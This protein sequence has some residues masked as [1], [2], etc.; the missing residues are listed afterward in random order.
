MRASSFM[1]LQMHYDSTAQDEVVK[2]TSGFRLKFSSPRKEELWMLRA[3]GGVRLFKPDGVMPP[4]RPAFFDTHACFM[5]SDRPMRVIL[6][7]PHMHLS[8]WRMWADVFRYNA[9]SRRIDKVAELGRT[10]AYNFHSQEVLRLAVDVLPGD[11]I[12]TT[13]IY[14]TTSRNSV[15]RAGPATKDECVAR[16]CCLVVREA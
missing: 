6:A 8:G 7:S 1:A 12:S 3:G 5:S 15:T 13:C 4:G 2:D 10:Q 11:V 16:C 14:N 9:Q